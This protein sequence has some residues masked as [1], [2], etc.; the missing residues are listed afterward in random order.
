MKLPPSIRNLM[1][2]LL[3][4]QFRYVL[5][6]VSVVILLLGYL[7]LLQPQLE[8]VQQQGV[9]QLQEVEQ[10]LEQRRQYLGRLQDMVKK[11]QDVVS[12]QPI[13]ITE[14]L[15]AE[16]EIGKLFLTFE[17]LI[18]DVG[19]SLDSVA[20]T[21]GQSLGSTTGTTGTK[22]TGTSSTIQVLDI[23][24]GI[25]GTINYET[26]KRLMTNFQRSVRIFDVPQITFNPVSADA[27]AVAGTTTTTTDRMSLEVKTYYLEQSTTK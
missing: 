23:S 25:G 20:V 12:E 7:L 4:T 1:T 2:Q 17:Q 19:L 22:T 15:P 27:T 11:Y 18:K 14:I 3:T 8:N 9:G 24:L 21:K 16:P 5:I 6:G 26:F 10:R 13:P